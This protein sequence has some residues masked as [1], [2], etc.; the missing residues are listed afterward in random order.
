MRFLISGGS[1]SSF[2]SFGFSVGRSICVVA[3]VDSSARENIAS[4]GSS[5][6]H[7]LIIGAVLAA[8]FASSFRVL[9]RGILMMRDEV[10]IL[11]GVMQLKA[12]LQKQ[13]AEN[14]QKTA[15][16]SALRIDQRPAACEGEHKSVIA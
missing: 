10:S 11:Q 8:L 4:R 2:D 1:W 13:N 5:K 14:E 16:A 15:L 12:N 9:L 3:C 6:L 7:T